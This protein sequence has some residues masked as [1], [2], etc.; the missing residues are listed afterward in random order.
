GTYN[1]I[2]GT[3]DE[4]DGVST[5]QLAKNGTTIGTV[6]L[7]QNLNGNAASAATKVE[8]V[9]AT[10]VA[11]ANGDTLTVTGAE[12]AGEHAR[13]DFIRFEPTGSGPVTPPP[14]PQP[15]LFEAE[16]ASAIVNYRT[17]SIA[18]ASGG[19]VLTLLGGASNESGSATFGFNE[20]PGVY[21]V[22]IGTFDENDGLASFQVALND[23]ETGT[24]TTI[25]Q[26]LLNANLG[27]SIANAQTKISPKVA[28]GIA[29][30]P[31][32]SITV[33]GFENSLEHARLDF[34]QLVPTV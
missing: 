5:F 11:I 16:N 2:L 27:S 24:T 8:K 9:F 19:Q 32:D 14:T 20:A 31:G 10:G 12:N 28:L 4:N 25:G 15:I 29:L 22:I 6:L 30:T 18:A 23:F 33:T 1:V 17:E 34:L 7:N 26:L 3:F 13:F 21:D